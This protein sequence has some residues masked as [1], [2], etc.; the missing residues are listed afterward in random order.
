MTYKCWQGADRPV[1]DGAMVTRL[2]LGADEDAPALA[3]AAVAR[4]ADGASEDVLER[5]KLLVSEVVTNSV[6]YAGGHE[7]RVEIWP[8]GASLAVIVSDDGPG[9]AP[10]ARPPSV[11]GNGGLG[12]ALVDMLAEAWGSG[13]DGESW[14]WFEVSPGIVPRTLEEVPAGA[15]RELLDVTVVVDSVKDHALVALDLAGTVTSWRA[16][17]AALTGYD[18]QDVLGRPLSQLF[19]ESDPQAFLRELADAQTGGVQEVERWITRKDGSRLWTDVVTA[20]IVDHHGTVRG[21]SIL[22]SDASARK[23]L[24][25]ARKALIAG[26]R[27]L[28]LTDDLTGLPNR[29]R[30]SQELDRDLARARRHGTPLVVA[31]LD[32]DGFK[33]Y[34]DSHGHPGGDELL[35]E[36]AR[37]WSEAVRTTD[38]LARYGGDEFAITLPEC[39]PA[40][41]LAVI[42]RVQE[43]MPDG[44]GCSVGLAS[45]DGSESADTLVARAD[46]A[47]YD[48]KRRGEAV[49]VA[50][51][52]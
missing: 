16:V 1:P 15:G 19:A 3:R 38:M 31:M 23:E 4:V 26:L 35:R 6:L 29:R 42:G 25:N 2:R 18:A 7:V 45:S 40:T 46:S 12:L 36:V 43:A 47:L 11:D 17:A 39:S 24:D 52:A 27:E 28:A 5:S 44:I 8:A 21:Y 20:P 33:E 41:A 34:N 9:F 30:W 51:A 13:S 37:Q 48:A 22:I 50:A 10:F 32:L 49:V 14:V